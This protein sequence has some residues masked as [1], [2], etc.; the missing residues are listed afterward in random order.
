MEANLETYLSKQ[1]LLSSKGEIPN[2]TDT[3]WCHQAYMDLQ[4][5]FE[6][7]VTY[8]NVV[9]EYFSN[10]TMSEHF[11]TLDAVHMLDLCRLKASLTEQ[12]IDIDKSLL[13]TPLKEILKFP[14]FLLNAELSNLFVQRFSQLSQEGYG[15]DRTDIEEENG[16]LPGLYLLLIHPVK[17]VSK[18]GPPTHTHA[19]V[20]TFFLS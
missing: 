2:D 13:L 6:C 7:V 3:A 18:C 14:R 5:C 10:E 9:K 16:I 4:S 19:Q 11:C 8:H 15:L 17:T 20:K 12:L 1:K